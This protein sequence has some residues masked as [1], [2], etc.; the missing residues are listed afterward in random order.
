MSER[1]SRRGFL[2]STAIGGAG[3]LILGNSASARR[4]EANEK[5]NIA[6]VGV[7]GRGSWFVGAMPNA[8]TSV[9]AMCDVNEHKASRAFESAPKARKFNDFRKMLDAMDKE[10]DA[11]TVATPDNTHAVISATA[12]KMGKGVLVEKPLTHDIFE[13]RRLLSLIH[14]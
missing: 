4:Y 12:M 2:G 5:L 1:M 6:L 9:V 7:S 11:V 8:G 3:L 10:I 13:A 14:I